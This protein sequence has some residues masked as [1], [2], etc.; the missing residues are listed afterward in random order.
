MRAS[1]EPL[2]VILYDKNFHAV[3]EIGDPKFVTVT[4]R[5][6]K[7]SSG[8]VGVAIN[9]S[10]IPEIIADGAR[11]VI[12]DENDEEVVSGYINDINGTGPSMAGQLEFTIEGYL[13]DLDDILGWVV[14]GAAITGQGT[15]GQNWALTGPAETV[16]KSAVTANA[17]RLGKPLTCAPSLG[18]GATV[19]AR[20]RM[21]PLGTRLLPVVDGAGIEKAG[22]GIKITQVD[23]VGLLLD[24]FEPSLYPADLTE[25]GG[26]IEEWKWSRTT[27]AATRVVVGGQGEAQ[28]RVFRE[29]VDAPREAKYGRIRERWRDARDT[30]D[31]TE[32]YERGQEVLDEG[33]AKVGLS[34]KFAETD[35]F[36]YGVHARV[37]DRLR[38][39][40]AEGIPPIEDVLTEATRSWTA[41]E[42]WRVSP[43]V[44]EIDDSTDTMLARAIKRIALAVADTQRR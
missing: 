27:A 10:R 23:D 41:D 31:P 26:A 12:R 16:L 11:C 37:G 1:V 5:F 38:L 36:R 40:V 33:A 7:K 44:G 19:K 6:N 2:R 13:V 43:K 22:I 30:D 20:L 24:V 34:V 4:E 15:A 18:R 9:H 21:H 39:L 8:R 3:G 28:A 29:I 14:P 42:G 35:N 17:T 25:D 32:L